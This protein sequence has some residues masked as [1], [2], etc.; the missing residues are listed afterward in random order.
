MTVP[1]LNTASVY[2]SPACRALRVRQRRR[3]LRQ[4]V[5]QPQ[6][7]DFF[8]HA[9]LLQPAAQVV[10]VDAIEL[11]ILVIAGE[12]ELLAAGRRVDVPLQALRANFLHHALHRWKHQLHPD[13]CLHHH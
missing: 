13:T 9:V 5:R 3:R 8:L 10:E 12:D 1:G 2:P 6:V 4:D 11:L 7:G